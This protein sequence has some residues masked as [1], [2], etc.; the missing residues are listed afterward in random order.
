[1]G[2]FFKKNGKSLLLVL[3]LLLNALGGSGVIPPVLSKVGNAAID[4]AQK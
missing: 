1:M 4:A 3:S 2:A